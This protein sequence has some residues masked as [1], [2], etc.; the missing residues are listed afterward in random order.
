MPV[1]VYNISLYVENIHTQEHRYKNQIHCWIEK[2][3]SIEI[4]SYI[5]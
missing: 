2:N 1:A 5:Q 3:N 4:T